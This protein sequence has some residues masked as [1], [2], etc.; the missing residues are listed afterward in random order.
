MRT[1]IQIGFRIGNTKKTDR[2][3]TENLPIFRQPQE[4]E[5]LQ[6]H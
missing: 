5:P 1:Y 2:K 4:I 6:L 3:V